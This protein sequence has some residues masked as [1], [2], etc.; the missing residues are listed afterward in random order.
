MNTGPGPSVCERGVALAPSVCERGV[1]VIVGVLPVPAQCM[2]GVCD[3]PLRGVSG[4]SCIRQ[5]ILLHQ[6]GGQS[7][8]CVCVCLSAC[9]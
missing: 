5:H 6:Q 8:G 2:A 7:P 4:R 9:I 3:S 1:A